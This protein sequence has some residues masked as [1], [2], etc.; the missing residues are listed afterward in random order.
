MLK[1]SGLENADAGV[2]EEAVHI[3]AEIAQPHAGITSRPAL[4]EFG[5]HLFQE[6]VVVVQFLEGDQP[7]DQGAG[8]A[9]FDAGRE[10]E[11]Q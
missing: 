1:L 4:A 11:Q 7:A 3:G 2:A 10:Q 9:G 6:R 8:L 5:D